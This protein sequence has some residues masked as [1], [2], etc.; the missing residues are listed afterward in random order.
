[1]NSQR[2]TDISQQL[3]SAPVGRLLLKLAVPTVV[4]QLVNLLYNIV[5][6]IYIGHM[7]EVGMTALT[8]IGLCF[9][10]IYL[11]GAFTMLV[12]QGGAP[13][14]AIAMG[15]GNNEK[16]EKIM[17]SCFTCLIG[18]AI[19]LTA[20]F[21]IFGEQLLW[22]FGCSEET[23]VYAL[24][25]MR[26][27]SSGSL[28]VMMS[29]GMNLF[30]TTQGFTT[31]SMRTVLIGAISN[32]VLD[33]IFI[34]V[35]NMGVQGAALA[36]VISQAISGVWV[37]RFLLGPKTKLRLR[38][39]KLKPKMSIVGPVLALGLAPFIMQAT[40][41]LLS[42][43]FNS[44]LQ[45][46]GGDIAVGAM[47]VASTVMQIVWIP[48]Q[49]LGQGAQPIISFNYGAKN[50]QRVREAFRALLVV[51]LTVMVAFWA[52]VQ[53]FPRFFIGIFNSDPQLLDTAV[54]TLRVYT[55]VLGLFGIQMAVQQ[56]FTAI[57]KAKAS[58][59]IACLRKV[60]LLIPLIFILP[61]FF[62]NKV[63]AVF[64]AEPVSDFISVAASAITFYLVFRPAMAELENE[65]K[66]L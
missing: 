39:D 33:P 57:G 37:V 13:R 20:L 31:F 59:F 22:I 56:T 43:S 19:A 45:H 40:E 28:F 7:P 30:V 10:V 12:A 61:N 32:I 62:E 24:P 58:L 36:T 11:I 21:W 49:G 46:Y 35:L 51:S 65:K 55:A 8:G 17:G 42:I 2:N 53:L 29:L 26:I 14:A 41:A 54:W 18:T 50:P 25:Y 3:S 4:A 9:P 63:F 27:Y 5:D 34:Y 38:R 23:I 44:S 48:T 64:L 1:M 16:A 60:I 15:E 6:R 66:S 52:A 47:T